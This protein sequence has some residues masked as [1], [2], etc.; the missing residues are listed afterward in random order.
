MIQ[1]S[2]HVLYTIKFKKTTKYHLKLFSTFIQYR[3]LTPYC[4]VI[5]TVNKD[6]VITVLLISDSILCLFLI[7]DMY[8]LTVPSDDIE[9]V[10]TKHL[11]EEEIANGITLNNK[12][13]TI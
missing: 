11:T 8:I 12:I 7:N 5:T 4:N 6:D 13:T 2:S 3:A 9:I 1:N 10:N